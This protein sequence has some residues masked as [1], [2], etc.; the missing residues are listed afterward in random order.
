MP[1]YRITAIGVEGSEFVYEIMGDEETT[2][3][4][5]VLHVYWLHGQALASGEQDEPLSPQYIA[6]DI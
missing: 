5:A 3:Q 2:P 6:E 4:E 1:T